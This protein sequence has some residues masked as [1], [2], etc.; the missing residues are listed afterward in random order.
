MKSLTM[1]CP[2]PEASSLLGCIPRRR[3]PACRD[4]SHAGDLQLAGMY[5]TP[6]TPRLNEMN[7]ANKEHVTV[8]QQYY[9]LP[10]LRVLN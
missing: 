1:N 4:V 3:P 5:P 9:I 2:T 8:V 10:S 7:K 6:E